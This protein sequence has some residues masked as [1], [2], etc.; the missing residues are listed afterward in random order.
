MADL[1]PDT[2]CSAC[3]KSHTLDDSSP[4]WHPPGASYSY[5]CPATQRVVT[6][7][8]SAARTIALPVPFDAIPMQWVSD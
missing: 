6:L 5:T 4:A 8:P 2:P 3:L 1:F 7:R